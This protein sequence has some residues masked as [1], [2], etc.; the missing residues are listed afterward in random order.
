MGGEGFGGNI[1]RGEWARRERKESER[2]KRRRR[3]IK[4]TLKGF[5]LS[6]RLDFFALR[7]L[8]G[9]DAT[10][11][12]LACWNGQGWPLMAAVLRMIVLWLVVYLARKE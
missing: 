6:S 1:H 8:L 7:P 9:L 10:V 2:K 4:L 3:R 12:F 11:D 5:V